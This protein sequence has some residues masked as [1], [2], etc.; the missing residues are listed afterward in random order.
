ME[1]CVYWEQANKK[2]RQKNNM[3]FAICSAGDVVSCVGGPPEGL[4]GSCT[5]AS[6]AVEQ[7]VSWQPR[8]HML[9]TPFEAPKPWQRCT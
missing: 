1:W 5:G 6:A 7:T 4:P 8:R 9:N 3:R 2:G